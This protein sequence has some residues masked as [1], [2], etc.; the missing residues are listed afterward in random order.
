MCSISNNC[1]EIVPTQVLK[2]EEEVR[3]ASSRLQTKKILYSGG[4]SW[5][6][7]TLLLSRRAE[8]LDYDKQPS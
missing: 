4:L 1:L 7:T 6:T 2:G 5:L 3:N 8:C